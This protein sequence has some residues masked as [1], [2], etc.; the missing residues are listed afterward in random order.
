MEVLSRWT[1]S[2]QR[3]KSGGMIQWRF[4]TFC[5]EQMRSK[6]IAVIDFTVEVACAKDILRVEERAI[7]YKVLKKYLNIFFRKS[8]FIWKCPENLPIIA[9]TWLF[10][11]PF[12]K[13]LFRTFKMCS[14]REL[15]LKVLRRFKQLTVLEWN[16]FL[17]FFIQT[18]VFANSQHTK[19]DSSNFWWQITLENGSGILGK[20]FFFQQLILLWII[21]TC[22]E[23]E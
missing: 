1:H 15:E 11:F 14:L 4:C 13:E 3:A 7:N 6:L 9:I 21:R 5:W 20:N 22:R 18:T 8:T 19:N 23:L 2:F 10:R 17:H 16:A 12:R